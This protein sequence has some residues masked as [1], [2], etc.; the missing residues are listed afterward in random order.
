MLQQTDVAF[1]KQQ[2]HQQ[3]KL[4]N[5]QPELTLL[6]KCG[7]TGMLARSTGTQITLGGPGS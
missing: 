1:M 2:M 4:K 3:A 5:L 7:P 6:L